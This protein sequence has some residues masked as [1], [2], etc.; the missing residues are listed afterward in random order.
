MNA[1]IFLTGAI[2]FEVIG[3][4]CLKLSNG[5]EKIGYGM[6]SMVFYG[7]CFWL[8]APALK[9]IPTGIAY[10]IWSGLGI[11][12][13]TVIS[14]IFFAQK[15]E[16]FQYIFIGLILIGAVGLNLTTAKI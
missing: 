12:A 13:I 9:V 6:A 16:P 8:L 15:L 4:I 1:W 3:T 10:A 11:V 7:L 5:F 14:L 2:G